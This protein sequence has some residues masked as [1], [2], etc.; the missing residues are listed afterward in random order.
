M[1]K[2]SSSA[3]TRYRDTAPRVRR[4]RLFKRVSQSVERLASYLLARQNPSTYFDYVEAELGALPLANED[5]AVACCRLHNARSE[6][7]QR[8]FG[9]ACYE[10]HLLARSLLAARRA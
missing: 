4:E 10:L 8:E 3:L 2:P 6:A 9:A 1:I 5:F 7:I